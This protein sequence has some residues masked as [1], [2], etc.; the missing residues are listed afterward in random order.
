MKLY[1]S[2]FALFLFVFGLVPSAYS[3]AKFYRTVRQPTLWEKMNF[4]PKAECP[5]GLQD[6]AKGFLE[7]AGVDLGTRPIY[8]FFDIGET[9]G[10]SLTIA[11]V[12]LKVTDDDSLTGIRYRLALSLGDVEDNTYKLETL[13]RQF[14]C[15]RGHKYWSKK[16]CP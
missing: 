14:T 4:K 12:T 15:A 5:D 2:L 1:L 7:Q 13:G 10:R 3:Q 6:C 16:R 11:F 9:G 8:E